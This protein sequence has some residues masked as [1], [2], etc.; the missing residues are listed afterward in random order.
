MEP[1]D[2]SL[3]LPTPAPRAATDGRCAR[4]HM[5]MTVN[6]ATRLGEEK[7]CLV[8]AAGLEP[9]VPATTH[10]YLGAALGGVV[11]ALAGALVWATVAIV[12]EVEIGYVA[13]LVG[14]L[15]G[16]G[17]R[18]GARGVSAPG[19]RGLAGSVA[20]TGLAVAKYFIAA[21]FISKVGGISPLSSAAWHIFVANLSE[22]VSGLDVIFIM[23]AIAAAMRAAVREAR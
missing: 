23:L 8:C 9:D 1:A 10:T 20:L 3:S 7:V 5:D 4:C 6:T 14:Y 19:L 17:V 22:L 13:V 11:G 21:Y 12:G 2:P 18:L 15:T 16:Q